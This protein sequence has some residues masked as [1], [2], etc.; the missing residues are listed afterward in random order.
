M[1][2]YL[3]SGL[4]EIAISSDGR[5]LFVAAPGVPTSQIFAVNIDPEDQPLDPSENPRK[6]HQQIGQV[7]TFAGAQGMAATADPNR[8]AFTNTGYDTNGFG[9]LTITNDDP[10]SFTATANNYAALGLGDFKDYFDVNRA[11][12]VTVMRDGSYAFVAW[13]NDSSQRGVESIDG[14]QAGSNIGIIKDPFGPNPQ[15]VAA[16]RPIPQGQTTDLVLSNDNKYLYASYPTVSG[17]GGVYVFDVEEIIRTLENPED[18]KIDHLGRGVKSPYLNHFSLGQVSFSRFQ[19]VPIDDINPAISIAADY[20]IVT[21]DW[22]ANQF[23]YGVTS[24]TTRGPVATGG[25]PLGLSVSPPKLNKT[26]REEVQE[27]SRRIAIDLR[28]REEASDAEKEIIDKNIAK[29]QRNQKIA[30]LKVV[31]EEQDD[32]GVIEP[33]DGKNGIY[34]FTQGEDLEQTFYGTTSVIWKLAPVSPSVFSLGEDIRAQ[35]TNLPPGTTLATTLGVGGSTVQ[36]RVQ[37]YPGDIDFSEKFEIEA[38]NSNNAAKAAANTIVE[39]VTRTRNNPNLEFQGLI[40]NT[41]EDGLDGNNRPKRTLSFEEL[42]SGEKYNKLVAA[43][44]K[45]DSSKGNV[46]T[47]WRAKVDGERF[48][49]ISKILDI[50]AKKSTT[51]E[52]LFSTRQTIGKEELLLSQQITEEEDFFLTRL[53]GAEYQTAYRT[54]LTSFGRASNTIL[55]N[56]CY[57]VRKLRDF[58]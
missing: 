43:L 54:H 27:I 2:D 20:G 14:G 10:T 49:D 51:G 28:K 7:N 12:A 23:T 13:K 25:S 9:V 44:E 15:L 26:P 34:K 46:N 33:I 42:A 3:T 4:H 52:E 29:H 32:N 19:S 17:G 6:W 58:L 39:F 21:G 37:P 22:A 40:I 41:L 1:F 35:P 48:I 11:V 24:D 18:F 5:K 8:M 16:T 30:L 36:G 53:G 55:P 38:P 50:T 56:K 57:N 31:Q 45:L 47:F